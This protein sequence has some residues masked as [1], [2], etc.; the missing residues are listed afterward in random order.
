MTV[1]QRVKA[2]ALFKQNTHLDTHTHTSLTFLVTDRAISW[3]RKVRVK[4]S[5][6]TNQTTAM[7]RMAGSAGFSHAEKD[8][9]VRQVE[10]VAFSQAVA[11]LGCAVVILFKDDFFGAINERS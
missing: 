10:Y 8:N 3:Q 7:A 2:E 9:V 1:R 11:G 5:H 6:Q 4:I